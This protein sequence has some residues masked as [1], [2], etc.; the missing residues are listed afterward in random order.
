MFFVASCWAAGTYLHMWVGGDVFV[1]RLA[2]GASLG[3]LK[4]QSS[5]V[6]GTFFDAFPWQFD[7]HSHEFTFCIPMFFL[8][9]LQTN[10][11]IP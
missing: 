2:K 8:M 3:Y 11:C 7:T 5:L 10:L 9:S 6:C 1:P 4:P